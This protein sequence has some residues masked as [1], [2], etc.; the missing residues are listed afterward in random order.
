MFRRLL[1]FVRPRIAPSVARTH[2]NVCCTRRRLQHEGACIFHCRNTASDSLEHSVFC[3]IFQEFIDRILRLPRA[4]SSQE[5]GLLTESKSLLR[6][7]GIT[8]ELVRLFLVL[9]GSLGGHSELVRFF[10]LARGIR[11]CFRSALS[12]SLMSFWC[13]LGSFWGHLGAPWINV[14]VSCAHFGVPRDLFGLIF[15][16]LGSFWCVLD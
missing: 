13:L 15:A 8:W 12:S 9:L 4:G 16:S 11:M 5:W 6:L 7:F 3:R 1:E 2:W 10:R 14:G